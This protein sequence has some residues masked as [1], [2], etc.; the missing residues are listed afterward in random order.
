MLKTIVLS[1]FI[2]ATNVWAA[3][4]E[5]VSEDKSPE[6]IKLLKAVEKVFPQPMK[7]VIGSKINVKFTDLNGSKIEKLNSECDQKL[8][9][10]KVV[11]FIPGQSGT[12]QLD[13]VLLQVI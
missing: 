1:S 2:L 3:N 7:E 5:L 4:F 9:L 8:V 6:A 12:I 10:G 11:N 13:R